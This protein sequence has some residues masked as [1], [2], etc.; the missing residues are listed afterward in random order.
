MT[1]VS[2]EIIQRAIARLEAKAGYTLTCGA[3]LHT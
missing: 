3:C 1:D 2:D